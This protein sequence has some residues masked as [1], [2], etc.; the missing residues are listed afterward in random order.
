M[1]FNDMDTHSPPLDNIWAM[2]MVWRMRG[3]IIRTVLCCTVYNSRAQ[4]H[5]HCTNTS[6]SYRSTVSGLNLSIQFIINTCR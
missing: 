6:S 2:M 4:W 1:P 5:A 3:K